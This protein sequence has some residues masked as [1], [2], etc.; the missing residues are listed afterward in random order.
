MHIISK[1]YR[2][3]RGT[4]SPFDALTTLDLGVARNGVA[5]QWC[6]VCQMSVDTHSQSYNQAQ[7]WGQK[8]WCK[9]CGAVTASA[10]YYQVSDASQA[11]TS[12]LTKA[13]DWMNA[14]ETKG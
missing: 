12:L 9:R 4:G 7:V 11:P 10:V 3:R 5:C 2:F 8:H 14:S 13:T 6:R 1:G